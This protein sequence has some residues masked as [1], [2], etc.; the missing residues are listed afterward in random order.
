MI[1]TFDFSYPS[2][3]KIHT[4][5]AREWVP[6]GRPRGVVQIV[7]GVAE[8]IGR[9]DSVARFLASRGY[10][11]CG[12]DHLGHG[13]TAGG[14]F[15]YFGP[16]NGWDLVARDVRR[17][18]Q[19]EGEK[20]PNLPYVI[21]GHSMGSFLTRTYLIRWPGTVDAAVLS[22]TGQ[23]PAAAVASGKALSGSLCR[24]KG[25]DH[26]S[27]LVN[28]LSL[29]SYN[30]AFKPNR[31]SSDW[32]SR[33]EAAVDAYLA[34]PLCTFLPTVSMFRDMMGGLQFIASRANLAKMNK[35]TPIYLLSG[36]RDPV[37][38][39][40]AGVRKVEGMLRSAGCR[41]VTV[42]LYPGGRHEMFN[43]INRQEVFND[44]IAWIESKLT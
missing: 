10:V 30:K 19:L 40:G 31:T 33:D 23:E 12:E 7:H 42:K 35:S 44:L 39:M 38:S 43:E 28:E 13:L 18:R 15:G 8:H 14:K 36:D 1:Q 21:L 16:K 5:H 22:G 20:L 3:D 24:L 41:D 11:V 27:R 26:V 29:G 25:P 4:V 32:L 9:Y 17:L 6:E 2:S 37:G 34:D